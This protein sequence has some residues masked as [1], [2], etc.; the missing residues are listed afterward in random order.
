MNKKLGKL[1][2]SLLRSVVHLQKAS[3]SDALRMVVE[4]QVSRIAG[5][6]NGATLVSFE[7]NKNQSIQLAKSFFITAI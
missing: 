1:L 6:S 7:G 4:F 2:E 5:N 3:V